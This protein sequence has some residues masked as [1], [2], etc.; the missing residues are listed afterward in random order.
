MKGEKVSPHAQ[1]K[2]SQK[3]CDRQSFF[4]RGETKSPS[5]RLKLSYLPTHSFGVI[6]VRSQPL[7]CSS[8]LKTHPPP[9][10]SPPLFDFIPQDLSEWKE[11]EEGLNNLFSMAVYIPP[12]LPIIPRSPPPPRPVLISC[13][14]GAAIRPSQRKRGEGSL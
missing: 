2:R 5:Y 9:S 3:H 13:S 6:L 7:W 11:E 8:A 14:I 10:S 4:Y 1:E 12:P